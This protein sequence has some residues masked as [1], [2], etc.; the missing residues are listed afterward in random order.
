MQCDENTARQVGALRLAAMGHLMCVAMPPL[1]HAE[2]LKAISSE[3]ASAFIGL[4]YSTAP[5]FVGDCTFGRVRDERREKKSEGEGRD[6]CHVVWKMD[7]ANNFTV[8]RNGPLPS[9]LRFRVSSDVLLFARVPPLPLPSSPFLPRGFSPV[10]QTTGDNEPQSPVD[11]HNFVLFALARA[12]KWQYAEKI[13][14]GNCKVRLVYYMRESGATPIMV[15]HGGSDNHKTPYDRVKRCRECKQDIKGSEHANV[16]VFTQNKRPFPNTAIP[17]FFYN[18]C[19]DLGKVLN[20]H[21][22]TGMKERR[23]Q[24]FRIAPDDAAGRRVFLGI[25]RFPPLLHSGDAPYSSRFAAIGSRDINCA[26]SYPWLFPHIVLFGRKLPRPLSTDHSWVLMLACTELP[27]VCGCCDTKHRS[28]VVATREHVQHR[29]PLTGASKRMSIYA[30]SLWRDF[31]SFV[32]TWRRNTLEVELMRGFRTVGSNGEWTILLEEGP[33]ARTLLDVN[34]VS[35][36]AERI[37]SRS[38][39]ASQK[40]LSAVPTPRRERERESERRCT[41]GAH[42]RTLSGSHVVFKSNLKYQ[43]MILLFLKQSSRAP[44]ALCLEGGSRVVFTGL[45]HLGR[46][47]LKSCG[48][49]PPSGGSNLECRTMARRLRERERERVLGPY[50]CAGTSVDLCFTAFGVGPLVFVRGS[51]NTEAYCNILD[52]EMLPTLWRFFG[53]DPCYFQDDNAK[54]HFLAVFLPLPLPSP[55]P[56]DEECCSV[57]AAPGSLDP[58]RSFYSL[59]LDIVM[60]GGGGLTSHGAYLAPLPNIISHSPD[61]MLLD[62]DDNLQ[63]QFRHGKKNSKNNSVIQYR[64]SSAHV[65]DLRNLRMDAAAAPFEN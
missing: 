28:A 52:N 48:P 7:I 35:Q 55:P 24:N 5:L 45:L 43:D 44:L 49:T 12:G 62:R 25:F 10:V 63:S 33:K 56:Y 18:R 38:L 19:N 61:R 47:P 27:R 30:L 3:L 54:C 22:R 58:S 2:R 51:M 37:L 50:L 1:S 31:P 16:D 64:I 39:L 26:V 53:M 29:L 34:V 65:N 6:N 36:F 42:S 23:Q 41:L 21:C 46:S 60:G 11:N 8:V 57:T 17:N 59:L 15:V 32:C 9:P 20:G 4:N 14:W 40:V 13:L